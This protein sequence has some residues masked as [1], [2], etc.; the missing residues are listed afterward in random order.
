MYSFDFQRKEKGNFLFGREYQR[1]TEGKGE[2][3]PLPFS[4]YGRHNNLLEC[5]Y[6][7]LS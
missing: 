3:A 2:C 4:S 1:K 7:G 6:S 5:L